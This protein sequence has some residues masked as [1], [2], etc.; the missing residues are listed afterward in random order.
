MPDGIGRDHGIWGD[1]KQVTAIVSRAIGSHGT[2]S[3][4]YILNSERYQVYTQNTNYHG[5]C[6]DIMLYLRE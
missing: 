6:M 5:V 3:T 1:S 2:S 4:W